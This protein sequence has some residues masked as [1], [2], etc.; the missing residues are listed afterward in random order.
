MKKIYAVLLCLTMLALSSTIA[1]A[2]DKNNQDDIMPEWVYLGTERVPSIYNPNGT[3]VVYGFDRASAR[4]G[5]SKGEFVFLLAKKTKAKNEIELINVRM[6]KDRKSYR[7]LQ[8]IGFYLDGGFKFAEGLNGKLSKSMTPETVFYNAFD[9]W[10]AGANARVELMD[11]PQMMEGFNQFM[12]KSGKPR[13]EKWYCFLDD[14][15]TGLDKDDSKL[16]SVVTYAFNP[17]ERIYSKEISHCE[18]TGDTEYRVVDGNAKLYTYE[19]KLL[20][21]KNSISA[22]SVAPQDLDETASYYYMFYRYQK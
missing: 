8:T 1:F 18:R 5:K 17:E 16:L 14:R 22:S 2:G 10:K 9:I 11:M 7:E 20:M 3:E 12:L 4:V 13:F 19:N 21:E 15:S 6:S